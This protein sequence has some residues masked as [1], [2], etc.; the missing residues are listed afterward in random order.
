MG[1]GVAVVDS[2]QDLSLIVSDLQIA[3]A[4]GLDICAHARVQRSHLPA[5]IMTG[6]ASVS[7]TI[8]AMRAGIGDYLVK[9]LCLEELEV[10]ARR[11]IEHARLAH[12]VERLRR[13]VG[14]RAARGERSPRACARG[15]TSTSARRPGTDVC[16]G[17][18]ARMRHQRA[19][20][21]GL[22]P[23]PWALAGLVE[24][25]IRACSPV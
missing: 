21:R 8:A 15:L 20:K 14:H 18:A 13:E 9:P 4:S 22:L 1:D 12:E 11:A 3:S 17:Q 25:A 5:I 10:Q 16:R 2:D 19:K 6:H 7:T 23:C 24:R